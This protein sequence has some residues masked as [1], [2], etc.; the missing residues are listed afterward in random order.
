MMRHRLRR[1]FLGAVLAMLV[2]APV[3]AAAA[4][5][6]DPVDVVSTAVG[7]A[8]TDKA[9]DTY[10]GIGRVDHDRLAGTRTVSFSFG[11][12]LALETCA[13]GTQARD[14]ATFTSRKAKIG[15]NSVAADLSSAVVA[16]VASGERVRTDGCTGLVESRRSEKHAFAYTLTAVSTTVTSVEACR[17][18]GAAGGV[19]VTET[20]TSADATAHAA[21]DL[22]PVTIAFASLLH[23]EQSIGGSCPLP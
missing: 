3:A 8:F 20:R 10:F 6:T 7:F 9:G 12:G 4:G 19:L 21:L 18:D 15:V 1:G 2:A 22:T 13:D 23:L 11:G 17:D 5:P 14:I 16:F